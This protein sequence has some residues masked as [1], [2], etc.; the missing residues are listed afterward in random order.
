[1][2]A[3][4]QPAINFQTDPFDQNMEICKEIPLWDR[5]D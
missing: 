2:T 4:L 5:M 1:M 3:L